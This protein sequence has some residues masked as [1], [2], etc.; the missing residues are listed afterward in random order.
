MNA[1]SANRNDFNLSKIL[2][3]NRKHYFDN[4]ITYFEVNL[5]RV[6]SCYNIHFV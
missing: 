2:N 5:P 6:G 3:V 1:T 4:H